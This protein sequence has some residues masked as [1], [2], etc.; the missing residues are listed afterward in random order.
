MK[1]IFWIRGNPSVPLAVVLCPPGGRGLHDEL[2][3]IKSKG[4][5]TLVSLLEQEEAAILGLSQE[6]RLAEQVGLQ[7]LSYP[8]PDARLPQSTTFFRSFIAGMADRL[9]DGESVGIHCRGSI[10]RATVAA[11][12]ALI[13]LGWSPKAALAAI[14]AARGQAVPDTQ[15]QEDWILRYKPLP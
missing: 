7:F 4:I 3:R 8:I 11:A 13:H 15:E 12:C 5:D 10:G 14:T 9:S 6:A 2:L 1:D